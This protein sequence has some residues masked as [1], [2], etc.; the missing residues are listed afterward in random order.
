MLP[1]TNYFVPRAPN[2]TTP[3]FPTTN[4]PATAINVS[5]QPSGPPSPNIQQHNSEP[6]HP[7]DLP[8]PNSIF[9]P[10]LTA[11]IPR[12]PLINQPLVHNTF[13]NNTNGVHK[14]VRSVDPPVPNIP[15]IPLGQHI[16]SNTSH[17]RF[18]TAHTVISQSRHYYRI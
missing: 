9:A 1:T 3:P 18:S 6:L 7:N 15:N 11:S 2:A 17:W 13:Q 12:A 10:N 8:I 4:H 14:V 5:L 16:V